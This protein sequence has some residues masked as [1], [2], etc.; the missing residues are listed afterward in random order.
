MNSSSLQFARSFRF[1]A[2]GSLALAAAGTAS[3]ANVTN[4]TV[5]YNSD[6][7][8]VANSTSVSF[9]IDGGGAND[10]TIFAQNGKA[11][12]PPS[13]MKP[14]GKPGKIAKGYLSGT[15]GNFLTSALSYGQTV[16][17]NNAPN[18]TTSSLSGE[19]YYGFSFIQGSTLYGWM[20]VSFT[21]PT[22]YTPSVQ[23]LEWGYDTTGAAITVGATAGVIPEPAT[24]TAAAALL[25]G[26]FA[27][28]RRRQT[29]VAAAA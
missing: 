25:A 18:F 7:G 14:G 27:A 8:I 1:G 2:T 10:F 12:K 29:R 11:A 22:V 3:A 26:S 16:G 5:V 24:T 20:K 15:S 17:P 13:K 28:W 4:G 9:D 19:N 23:V 6:P 21:A